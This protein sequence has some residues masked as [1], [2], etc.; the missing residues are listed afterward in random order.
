[1]PELPEVETIRR[2]LQKKI[3]DL[4]ISDVEILNPKSFQADPSLV[5]NKQ[6]VDVTRRAKVLGIQLDNGY[7][8]VFHL[9]M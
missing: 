1:M 3:I 6:V 2:G 8:L 4:K 5:I 7:T 9:K